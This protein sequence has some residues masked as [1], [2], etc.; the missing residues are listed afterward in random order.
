MIRLGEMYLIAAECQYRAT[1]SGLET[2]NQL[3]GARGVP[4]LE[5]Q[6]SDFYAELIRE[7]RRELL[8]EG[9]LF[10]L[11]KRLNRPSVSGSDKDMVGEKAYTFPLPLSE[12]DAAQREN[13]R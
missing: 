4:A 6:P 10:F 2:L 12:T 8:G 5:N 7:Y 9:Q 1:G 13:N 3:R 11:Y